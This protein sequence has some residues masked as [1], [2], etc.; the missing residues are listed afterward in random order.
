MDYA[1][2]PPEI[3][4][5]RIYSGPGCSCLLTAA[6]SWDEIAAELRV[7]ADAY[8]SVALNLV[9]MHW[10]G[11]ASASMLHA[12]STVASWLAM[13]AD[14]AARS[15]CQAK[16]AAAAYELARAASVAPPLIAANRQDL[17]LLNGTNIFGQN[18]PAIAVAETEYAEMWACD[19]EAMYTYAGASSLAARLDP[20]VPPQETPNRDGN[21]VARAAR[22]QEPHS[23]MLIA[24][25]LQKLAAP[26]APSVPDPLDF[27]RFGYNTISA[28]NDASSLASNLMNP[29]INFG[30]LG[31]AIK[32]AAAVAANGPAAAAGMVGA[33]TLSS[34]SSTAVQAGVGHAAKV[35]HLAVPPS[36][37]A[38][39]GGARSASMSGTTMAVVPGTETWHSPVPC[40]PGTYAKRGASVEPRYGKPSTVMP[41][42]PW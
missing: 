7:A 11:A 35:G 40:T 13:T 19:A 5:S 27:A 37:T 12:A 42:A 33:P 39:T 17:M 38:L 14:Q 31:N 22:S 18:M 8:E 16:A 26:Q 28:N 1:M 30:Q 9:G 29:F 34:A 15:A 2:L 41:S 3:N 6:C 23:Q 32:P 10:R 36:W 24:R 25:A 4:S 21:S 20:F